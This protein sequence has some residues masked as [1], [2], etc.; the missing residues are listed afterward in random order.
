MGGKDTMPQRRALISAVAAMA[1][2]ALAAPPAAR[3][4]DLL[5]T[6]EWLAERLSE[7]NLTI[8][9]VATDRAHYDKGHIPGA[10]FV[11]WKAITAPRAG[12][13]N[14]LPLVSDL[15]RLF[16]QLGVGNE[17]RIV[18]YGDQKGLS[19]ARTFFTLDYLG[20][21]QRAALLDGGLEKWRAEHRPVSTEVPPEAARPFFARVS[22]GI[23]VGLDAVRDISW[24][25][26][27]QTPAP[28][29]LID[30]RPAAQF[31]GVEPGEDV[32]RPGHIP[33][34]RNIF[35]EQHLTGGD[36]P[37]LKSPAE[38]KALYANAGATAGTP[39]VTY[40]RTGGQ[41]SHAYFVAKYLGYDV[42]MYDGSFVEWSRADN[43][44]VTGR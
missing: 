39:V 41:A 21:G 16:Q 33:G 3:G 44:E 17:G 1:M 2:L 27:H 6:T 12:V 34:A 26:T 5:V 9:H 30:A 24:S 15:V 8:L 18:I 13:P 32:R 40:C 20:H 25:A 4:Q 36:V 38:L 28:W 29:I 11:A 7:P 19:A 43:T 23:V 22:P 14:E 35:W 10:R 42:R 31:S 37:V